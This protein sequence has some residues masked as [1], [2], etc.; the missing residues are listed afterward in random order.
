LNWNKVGKSSSSRFK[1]LQEP[2]I[3]FSGDMTY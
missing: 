3:A 2:A 1:F